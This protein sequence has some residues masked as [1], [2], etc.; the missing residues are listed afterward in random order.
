MHRGGGAISYA[1]ANLFGSEKDR[2]VDKDYLILKLPRPTGGLVIYD[3]TN[4]Q[5]TGDAFIG[6]I[7]LK[8]QTEQYRLCAMERDSVR[9]SDA[10]VLL[11]PKVIAAVGGII[12]IAHTMCEY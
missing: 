6:T 7:G 10:R 5:L 8:W 3:I 9:A 11:A 12:G 2:W 1:V 4:N